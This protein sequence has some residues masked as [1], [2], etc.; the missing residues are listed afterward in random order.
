MLIALEF[1]N[2]CTG[3]RACGVRWSVKC[4]GKLAPHKEAI[5]LA[6]GETKVVTLSAAGCDGDW[7]IQPP[8]WSCRSPKTRA[9]NVPAMPAVPKPNV[10]PID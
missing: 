3:A 10:N 7:E 8:T 4:V 1:H 5:T 9:Q 6:A 2:E